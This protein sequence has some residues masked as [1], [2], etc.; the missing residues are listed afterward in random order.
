MNK[1]ILLGLLLIPVSMMNAKW[2]V[3]AYLKHYASLGIEVHHAQNPLSL[4][5]FKGNERCL[6]YGCRSGN[7]SMIIAQHIPNG[8]LVAMDRE[9]NFIKEAYVK[10][11]APNIQYQKY[12]PHKLS[13]N[14]EFDLVFSFWDFHWQPDINVI[15]QSMHRALKKGGRALIT[16]IVEKGPQPYEYMLKTLQKP[17]WK[18]FR[19][20]SL[21]WHPRQTENILSASRACGFYPEF[22]HVSPNRDTFMSKQ[23]LRNIYHAIPLVP[24]IPDDLREVFIKEVIDDYT[25]DYPATPDGTYYQSAPVITLVLKK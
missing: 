3:D 18:E 11:P 25:R 17:A 4:I 10:N 1:R 12:N 6:Q 16:C 19:H 22:V 23:E 5:S 20:H 2:D 21:P 7:I 24:F 13:F 8:F 9:Q 14:Q 15:L